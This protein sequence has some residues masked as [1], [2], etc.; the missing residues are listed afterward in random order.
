MTAAVLP[1]TPVIALRRVSKTYG[2]GAGRVHAVRD[3]SLTVRRGEFVAII[4]ASGSGKSTLMNILALLDDVT[5]GSYRIDGVDVRHREEDDLAAIRNKRIG[6]VF[7]SFN[8]LTGLTAVQNVE[9]PLIYAGMRRSERQAAALEA[10]TAVGLARR[11]HHLPSELSGGEQQRV[12]VARAIVNDP[13]IVLADE[14]TGNLDTVASASVLN[15]LRRL[16]RQGRT[17]MVITHEHDVAAIA[18]R[19]VEMRDGRVV[20]DHVQ[21]PDGRSG[22]IGVGGQA[23]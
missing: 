1:G 11:A 17:V 6:L 12:A 7:Q 10:L 21:S 19:I 23:S 14:P 18:S 22:V 20:A 16:H 15:I 2:S 8:L 3:V 4:G 13:A 5:R 9:L